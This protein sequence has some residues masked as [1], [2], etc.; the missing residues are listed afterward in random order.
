MAWALPIVALLAGCDGGKDTGKKDEAA[1][2]HAVAT[3]V[4]SLIHI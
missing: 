1:K 4:L 3:Y 2:P